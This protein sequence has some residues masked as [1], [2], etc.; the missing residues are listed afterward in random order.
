MV[1][2]EVEDGEREGLE[3][4]AIARKRRRE[5][6]AFTPEKKRDHDRLPRSDGAASGD[7][8]ADGSGLRGGSPFL[9][10]FPNRLEGGR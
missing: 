4:A 9:L 6:Q 5:G 8:C 1:R 10:F 7:S 3:A 2:V